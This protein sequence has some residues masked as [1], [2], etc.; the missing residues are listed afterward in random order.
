M[1][2]P[3]ARV[4]PAFTAVLALPIRAT[5]SVVPPWMNTKFWLVLAM[6]V[7]VAPVDVIFA[8]ISATREVRSVS[9]VLVKTTT[10]FVPVAAPLEAENEPSAKPA[11]S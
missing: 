7:T 6:N 10:P 11:G 5:R 3:P 9:N 8:S 4:I 2:F 1:S